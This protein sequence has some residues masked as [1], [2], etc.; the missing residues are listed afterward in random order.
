M[1]KYT[2]YTILLSLVILSSCSSIQTL[3]FDQLCPAEVN[4]PYQISNVG[5]V[6]NMPSRPEP[7]KNILTLGKVEAEDKAQALRLISE[8]YRQEEIVLNENDYKGYEIRVISD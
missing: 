5:V 6:N 4:F 3:T 8:R 2:L 7:K 1:K